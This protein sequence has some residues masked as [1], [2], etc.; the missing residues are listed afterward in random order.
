M[1]I[2][3]H[4]LRYNTFFGKTKDSILYIFSLITRLSNLSRLHRTNDPLFHNTQ[5]YMKAYLV[6][7]V[8][9]YSLFPWELGESQRTFA[10]RILAKSN[11]CY[12]ND[13]NHKLSSESRWITSFWYINFKRPWDF[14]YI[15]INFMM[16]FFLRSFVPNSSQYKID[17][18]LNKS[19]TWWSIPP[20]MK[21]N[22]I[23]SA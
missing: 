10:N 4:S 22:G 16:A 1:I 3:F 11:L 9:F 6:S 17:L 2:S 12:A 13:E 5:Q 23:A 8:Q 15:L 18:P 19:H 20:T 14:L 21:L 7:F